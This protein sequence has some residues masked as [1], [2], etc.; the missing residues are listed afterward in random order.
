VH[1]ADAVA[2]YAVGILHATRAHPR[3]RL[4]ASTR[5]GVAMVSLARALAVMDGREY[6][7]PHDISRAAHSSLAH[8]LL[9]AGQ[10][11]QTATDVVAECVAA[12]QAPRR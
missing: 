11:G 8:R 1:L 12:V 4:G 10:A 5:A 2:A 6:V 3:V 9:V 7:A